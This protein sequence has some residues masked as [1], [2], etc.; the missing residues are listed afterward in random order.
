MFLS[1]ISPKSVAQ[2]IHAFLKS[3]G[4]TPYIAHASVLNL[5][6]VK[7]LSTLVGVHTEKSAFKINWS[8]IDQLL[9]I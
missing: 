8:L 6:T 2:V 1:R 3:S 4:H 7:P 5:S 9:W